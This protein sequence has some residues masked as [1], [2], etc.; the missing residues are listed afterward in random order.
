M[1]I[2]PF[3]L[4]HFDTFMCFVHFAINSKFKRTVTTCYFLQFLIVKDFCSFVFVFHTFTFYLLNNLFEYL[5]KIDSIK[6]IWQ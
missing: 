5:L 2:N 1:A 3:T 6:Y 4:L